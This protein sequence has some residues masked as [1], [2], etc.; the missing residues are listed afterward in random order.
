MEF[1]LNHGNFKA[2]LN[3][4]NRAFFLASGAFSALPEAVK[5]DQTSTYFLLLKYAYYAY[6]IQCIKDGVHDIL[7][8]DDFEEIVSKEQPNSN[9]PELIAELGNSIRSSLETSDSDDDK[10]KESVISP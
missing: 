10:K 5:A 1:I 6:Q 3:I 8:A 9:F 7:P 4:C 2:K